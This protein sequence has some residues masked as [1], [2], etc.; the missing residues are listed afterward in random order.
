MSS[1]LKV[2]NIKHE[3][4]GSNNLVLASDGS[5]TINEISSSTV[6]PAGHFVKSP[7]T[8][9]QTDQVSRTSSGDSDLISASISV[10]STS[11]KI[12]VYGSC[13]I[14]LYGNSAVT[15]AYGYVYLHDSTAGTDL[16]RVQPNEDVTATDAV[17]EKQITLMHL[18]TPSQ[19][20]TNT[21]KM[22]LKWGSGRILSRGNNEATF[23]KPCQ[24]TL[25]YIKG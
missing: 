16:I 25:F 13:S 1:D 8:A 3:S 11:D 18:A 17:S 23:I 19:T 9:F 21:Y 5:A 12:L 20:G 4:S 14:Q 15:A 22:Y 6:F 24:I 7:V 10:D 2:T